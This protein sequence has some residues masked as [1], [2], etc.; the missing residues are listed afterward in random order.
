LGIPTDKQIA[1]AK[2]MATERS[3]PLPIEVETDVRIC[4]RWIDEH[5]RHKPPKA[6]QIEVAMKLAE[7]VGVKPSAKILE[8]SKRLGRWINIK[9]KYAEEIKFPR[10]YSARP[11]EKQMAVIMKHAPMELAVAVKSGDYKAGYDFL[12]EFFL[13]R[14]KPIIEGDNK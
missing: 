1:L 4:S 2:E 3:I 13:K 7:K 5:Y 9:L 11:T 6:Y 12:D 14:E 10:N 8:S